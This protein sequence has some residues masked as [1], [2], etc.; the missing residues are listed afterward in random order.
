MCA[1]N[2]QQHFGRWNFSQITEWTAG[3]PLKMIKHHVRSHLL[4]IKSLQSAYLTRVVHFRWFWRRHLKP[5]ELFP[6][7]TFNWDPKNHN[8]ISNLEKKTVQIWKPKKKIEKFWTKK[9]EKNFLK[10]FTLTKIEKS[11][12]YGF[13]F[14]ISLW[15]SIASTPYKRSKWEKMKKYWRL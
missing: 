10:Y 2:M 7:I 6:V 9:I 12:I 15:E 1:I 5:L 8:Q 14:T 3:R 13:L 11:R 4:I